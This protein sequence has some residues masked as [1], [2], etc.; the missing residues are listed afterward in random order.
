MLESLEHVLEVDSHEED[1]ECEEVGVDV[2]KEPLD[3]IVVAHRR[4]VHL[5]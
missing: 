2:S 5:D 4:E 1:E 3:S